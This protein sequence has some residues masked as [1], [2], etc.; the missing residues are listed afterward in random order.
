MDNKGL[1][2][3]LVKNGTLKTESIIRAFESVDRINFCIPEQK[4]NAYQDEPLP[5]YEGQTISQPSTVALMTE[6]LDVHPGHKVLEI[7][8]GSGYQAAILSEI[9][10]KQGA[11]YTIEIVPK[12]YEFSK[13]NLKEYTNIHVIKGDG[14]LGLQEHAPYDRIIVTA[15]APVIHAS[16]EEQLAKGGKLVI[17]VFNLKSRI[18]R[19]SYRMKVITKDESGKISEK[20]GG[21][22][23]FVRLVGKNGWKT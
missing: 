11:V 10:G 23:T 15:G 14:S 7:G 18:E 2:E 22:F 4:Y 19:E 8:S 9:V 6:M 5:T 13:N 12:L 20:E 17:P 3:H 1:V 21:L 16:L